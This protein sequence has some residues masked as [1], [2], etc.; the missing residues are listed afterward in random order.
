MT[1]IAGVGGSDC[2]ALAASVL[3][4]GKGSRGS[5]AWWPALTFLRAGAGASAGAGAGGG[6]YGAGAGAGEG[7]Y[8]AGAYGAGAYGAG[9][10]GSGAY[11]AL[12]EELDDAELDELEEEAIATYLTIPVSFAAP[13]RPLNFGSR[14]PDLGCFVTASSSQVAA[15][16][17]C[18][19]FG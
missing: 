18:A 17:P 15:R 3:G 16:G 7:A 10:Y 9:A 11:G 14:A 4:A 19:F 5:D 2:A 13:D 12:D 1:R 6:A 8:G